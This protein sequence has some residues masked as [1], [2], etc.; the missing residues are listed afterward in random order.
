MREKDFK[1][2]KEVDPFTYEKKRPKKTIGGFIRC[3]PCCCFMTALCILFL[4]TSLVALILGLLQ[5]K[6]STGTSTTMTSE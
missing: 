5:T 3:S 2:S 4:L 1:F 6:K